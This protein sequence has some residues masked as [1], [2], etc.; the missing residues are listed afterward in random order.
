MLLL[1]HRPVLD[2]V[3]ELLDAVLDELFFVVVRVDDDLPKELA[4]LLLEVHV[5][6]EFSKVGK[7]VELFHS[8]LVRGGLRNLVEKVLD[9]VAL[10]VECRIVDHFEDLGLVVTLA[11][12]PELLQQLRGKEA[13]TRQD[14]E[15]LVR[16]LHEL[17]MGSLGV[18]EDVKDLLFLHPLD[19]L[20]HGEDFGAVEL[21]VPDDSVEFFDAEDA[22][23]QQGRRKTLRC[24][25][26]LEKFCLSFALIA[27][28]DA[29]VDGVDGNLNL[30]DVALGD[31]LKNAIL[32]AEELAFH[33]S[34]EL[35]SI[36]V[37]PRPMEQL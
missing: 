29:C 4:S 20:L 33:R 24:H 19:E 2:H 27:V 28:H 34:C 3:G 14:L 37:D 9:V 5:F 23:L 7:C 16:T 12:V 15:D 6:G 30:A 25:L 17:E 18:P 1:V 8:E 21:V 36:L 35:G 32:G 10:E 31:R 11:Q 13:L 22:A 26:E